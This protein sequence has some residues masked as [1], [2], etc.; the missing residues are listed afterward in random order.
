MEAIVKSDFDKCNGEFCSICDAENKTVIRG[1]VEYVGQIA[2]DFKFFSVY[3]GGAK[4][5]L[6]LSNDKDYQEEAIDRINAD[7]LIAEKAK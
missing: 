4:K 7:E 3:G 5:D 2:V 6:D 1:E